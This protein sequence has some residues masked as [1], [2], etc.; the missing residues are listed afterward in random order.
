MC[1]QFSARFAGTGQEVV[2]LVTS[3]LYYVVQLKQNQPRCEH[4]PYLKIG[5]PY[6]FLSYLLLWR[7]HLQRNVIF[8]LLYIHTRSIPLCKN[9]V[10]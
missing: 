4:I 3:S 5:V 1:V 6:H 7:L 10:S 9:T 8:L 2:E